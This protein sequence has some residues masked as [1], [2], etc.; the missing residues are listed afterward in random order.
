MSKQESYWLFWPFAE[1]VILL[2][3]TLLSLKSIILNYFD[4]KELEILFLY[5]IIVFAFCIFVVLISGVFDSNKNLA[6][7][8]TLLYLRAFARVL[9]FIYVVY[10]LGAAFKTDNN[11]LIRIE[12]SVLVFLALIAWIASFTRLIQVMRHVILEGE[13]SGDATD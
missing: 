13:G 11:T 8:N 7:N 12:L 10:S 1:G 6:V 5:D 2:S 4:L 9:A 3:V